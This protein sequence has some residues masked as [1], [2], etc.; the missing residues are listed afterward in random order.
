MSP[1]TTIFEPNPKRVSAIF[2]CSGVVFWAS[3]KIMAQFRGIVNERFTYSARIIETDYYRILFD[4]QNGAAESG[5]E[6][7]KT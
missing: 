4:A 3:S 2:I 5:S 6:S 7:D 1:V